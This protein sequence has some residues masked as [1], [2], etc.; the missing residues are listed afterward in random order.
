MNLVVPGFDPTVLAAS[1]SPDGPVQEISAG[2]LL[3]L[4]A[5]AEPADKLSWLWIDEAQ[6]DVIAAPI[7]VRF[8]W[9]KRSTS[10]WFRYNGI[11]WELVPYGAQTIDGSAIKDGTLDIA[12]LKIVDGSALKIPQVNSTGT[13]WQMVTVVSAIPVASLSIGKIVPGPART[14]PQVNAEGNAIGWQLIDQNYI[15]SQLRV[16]SL[17]PLVLQPGDATTYLQTDADGN[18]VWA[19]LTPI[20]GLVVNGSTTGKWLTN[21]GVNYMWSALP[22]GSINVT[23]LIG[24]TDKQILQTVGTTPTWVGLPA[25]LGRNVSG[26]IDLP[27]TWNPWY[28]SGSSWTYDVRWAHALGARPSK[29]SAVLVCKTS[30]AT[31]TAGKD[32]VDLH[33]LVSLGSFGQPFYMI[34]ADD[35]YVYM[36]KAVGIGSE[37]VVCGRGYVG[38]TVNPIETR[39][40]IQFNAEV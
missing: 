22:T 27:L 29:I 33:D 4:V 6:P 31:F 38:T 26:L 17:S 23:S 39:W 37:D 30:Y 18:I 32:T 10:E 13:A 3:Q 34:D 15:Y 12:A 20:P 9:Y 11:T 24:G 2:D 8:I 28:P 25:V 35:T 21:D 36:K 19:A 16:N 14:F 5:K 7:L 1:S 40:R